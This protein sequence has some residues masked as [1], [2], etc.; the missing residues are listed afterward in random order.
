MDGPGSPVSPA[1]AVSLNAAPAMPQSR[2]RGIAGER[3]L[4]ADLS[5]DRVHLL[6]QGALLVMWLPF[7]LAMSRPSWRILTIAR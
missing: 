7:W 2:G 5:A 1:K 6:V 3:R 4:L